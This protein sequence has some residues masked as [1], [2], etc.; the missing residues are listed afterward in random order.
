VA[1]GDLYVALNEF[2][3]YAGIPIASTQDDDALTTAIKSASRGI[4]DVCH[5][6]FND[7]AASPS[8]RVYYPT[9]S[10][11]V[12]VDDFHTT[13]GLVIKSAS[14]P[15]SG[16]YDDTWTTAD[17]ELRPLNGLVGGMPWPYNRIRPTG[18]RRF[19]QGARRAPVEVT[20]R[21]GWAAVP[22]PVKQAAIIVALEAFK[23]RD[24]P[25]GVAGFGEMGV[26][27]VRGNPIAMQ[28]LAPYVV[29]PVLV[30]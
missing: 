25:L 3:P 17:Y 7:V 19:A 12:V 1:I 27:R 16:V 18:A 2:K 6:Q 23:L 30:G 20:A 11:R 10:G 4:E 9:G 28:K 29:S 22:F 8:A 5:R 14:D 15:D 26:V 13:I 24:A 21:W